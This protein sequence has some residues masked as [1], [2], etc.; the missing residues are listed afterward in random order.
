MSTTISYVPETT[1]EAA[2]KCPPKVRE[3][4]P[5][6]A[7]AVARAMYDPERI[8]RDA[9]A[10]EQAN[11][12]TTPPDGN[13]SSFPL[14]RTPLAEFELIFN[15]RCRRRDV[16]IDI[17]GST[18]KNVNNPLLTYRGAK[19]FLEGMTSEIAERPPRAPR[20][21]DGLSELSYW[22][23]LLFRFHILKKE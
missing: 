10:C 12:A 3:R 5:S 20:P 4:C 9:F 23:P 19:R 13:R 16:I 21:A 17:I 15:S 7:G 11:N 14:P 22:R 2:P 6:C 1:S 18:H 8:A